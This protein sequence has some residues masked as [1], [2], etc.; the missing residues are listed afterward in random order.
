MTPTPAALLPPVLPNCPGSRP[1]S[2]RTYQV[3]SD[4][5]VDTDDGQ[6]VAPGDTFTADGSER[7]RALVDAGLIKPAASSQAKHTAESEET[8]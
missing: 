3:L 4:H 1:V 8:P 6:L 7:L 5:P 2:A